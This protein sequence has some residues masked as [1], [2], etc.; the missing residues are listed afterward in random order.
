MAKKRIHRKHK[1]AIRTNV[2]IGAPP[3]ALP[4]TSN[5]DLPKIRVMAYG[6]ETLEE[7]EVTTTKELKALK[8]KYRVLWV[9]V[10]GVAH[11]STVKKIG[12]VFGL[13]PLALEDVVHLGQRPKAETYDD[14]L[15][16][17]LQVPHV[18]DRLTLEQ[19][20]I[21]L[22]E[23]FVVTF[24]EDPKDCLAPVRERI[25][26]GKGRLR[27]SGADYLTYALVDAIVD[28][29][30]PALEQYGGLLDTLESHVMEQS[31]LDINTEIH[32]IRQELSSL[33]R[34]L[35][36]M[37]DTLSLLCRDA[38]DDFLPETTPFLRDCLDHATQL[39]DVV[40]SCREMGASL[41]DFHLS[42]MSHRMNEV[43]KVLTIIA[44]LF[45]PLSFIA[46]VYGMNFDQQ[47]SW[48][49]PELSWAYGYPFALGLMTATALGFVVYFR[50]KG[51]LGGRRS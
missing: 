31:G 17:V 19:V 37:R 22:G 21:F 43:M 2:S 12:A 39:M 26:T 38:S 5:Q 8:N 42:N 16:T 44:T 46:G 47:S 41:M 29:Y 40:E 23:G 25:R 13:H 32:A 11:G 48:N 4:K 1:L 7:F 30:F 35:W 10:D 34:L 9:D 36:A 28:H 49:M 51:W 50:R 24:Q 15:Y 45:I 6:R 3:G 20:S 33:R 27:K 18:T 14:H